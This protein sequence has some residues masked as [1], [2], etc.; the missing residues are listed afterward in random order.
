MH[1]HRC[2]RKKLKHQDMDVDRTDMDDRPDA[3]E[4]RRVLARQRSCMKAM[5][6]QPY[7]S[8]PSKVQAR[9]AAEKSETVGKEKRERLASW[10]SGISS[11]VT[12]EQW[13]RNRLATQ[14]PKTCRSGLCT[15]PAYDCCKGCYRP[16]CDAHI[17]AV[18]SN[19]DCQNSMVP[20][21][22]GESNTETCYIQ[23][24]EPNCQTV[25]CKEC[26]E[27]CNLCSEAVAECC[28]DACELCDEVVCYDCARRTNICDRCRNVGFDC[29]IKPDGSHC[30]LCEAA[31]SSESSSE[32]SEA[33]DDD[34]ASKSR[35]D[36]CDG[37]SHKTASSASE[38]KCGCPKRDWS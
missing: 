7:Q 10:L 6:F 21:C 2:A 29:C 25:V 20:C 14:A 12:S 13:R 33:S 30:A 3:V 28:A 19:G 35:C 26:A 34:E 4:Y 15:A 31:E 17:A 8:R 11:D 27:T 22:V 37:L 9:E 18:C 36:D 1:A 32:D 24:R 23:C 16:A 5:R 38:Y